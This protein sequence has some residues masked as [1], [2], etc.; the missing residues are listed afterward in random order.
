MAVQ[1]WEER[2]HGVSM[3]IHEQIG[4]PVRPLELMSYRYD[5]GSFYNRR[6][7]RDGILGR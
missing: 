3:P 5:V 7:R 2:S 6:K 4:G 1:K